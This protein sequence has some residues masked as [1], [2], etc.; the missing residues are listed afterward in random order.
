VS[1]HA[2]FRLREHLHAALWPI[3]CAF[4]LGGLLLGIIVWRIDRWEGWFLLDYDAGAATALISAIA[5]ATLTFLGTAFAVL[6]VVFQF[7]STQLTPRALRVS[8]SDPLYRT[9]LGLFVATFV[10]SLVILGRATK[11]FVPQLGLLLAAILVVVSLVAY[12]V[13]ISHL[14]IALRPVIVAARVG[15]LGRQALDRIYPEPFR[16]PS[17]GAAA[18]ATEPTRTLRNPGPP[19]TLVAFDAAGLIAEARRADALVMLVPAPGDFVRS[20]APLF[21]LFEPTAATSDRHLLRSVVL[22]RERTMDQDAA[23]AFRILVDVAVK[24]LSPAINDPTSAVMAIDQLHD[25]LAQLGSRQL[26]VGHHRDADGRVRLMIDRPTWE[27]YVSLAVDEIRHF[28]VE[29]LQVMRRLRAMFEDLQR[30]V[31]DERKAA[32]SR[33]LALLANAVKRTFPDP[34]DQQRASEP[35]EQGI[36]SSPRPAAGSDG[37]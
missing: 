27:D 20:G 11:T 19:G 15:R 18:A 29:Q 9:S 21:Q 37:R 22:Q 8:I 25:L 12:V 28:G 16:A 7:A 14:R 33:E 31:P 17:P 30:V 6:L 26:D 2:R 36:G 32:I 1:W 3:P 34:E 13:L 35:D 24:A 10:Y 5:A 4:G 23:L